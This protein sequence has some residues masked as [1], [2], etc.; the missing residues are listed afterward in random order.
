VTAVPDLDELSTPDPDDWISERSQ[1]G[2]S[3]FILFAVGASLLLAFCFLNLYSLPLGTVSVGALIDEA[4]SIYGSDVEVYGTMSHINDME[5]TLADS[6][7]T[8]TLN[9]VWLSGTD[10][11]LNG[12]RVVATGQVIQGTAGPAIMCRSIAVRTGSVASYEDPFTLPSLRV[13][14]TVMVWFIAMI[15]STGI[16]AV[17]NMR[18]RAER[19]KHVVRALIDASTVASGI[20]AAIMWTLVITEPSLGNSSGVLFYCVAI[21]FILLLVSSLSQYSRRADL[22]ELSKALPVIAAMVTLLGLSLSLLNLPATSEA[23]LFSEAG[24]HFQD[25][26]FAAA[27]GISGLICLSVY[28]AMRKSELSS[29]EGSIA[30]KMSGAR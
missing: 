27:V 12:A 20:L 11:P 23:T 26:A 1:G 19:A 25:S 9:V 8:A 3:D 16:I 21:A 30:E 7:S 2:A 29:I 6:N 22:K 24:L 10:L 13:M 28:I 4:P 18:K 17:A 5:F 14:S 15:F